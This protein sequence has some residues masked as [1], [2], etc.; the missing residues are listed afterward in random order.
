MTAVEV[1]EQVKVAGEIRHVSYISGS[2]TAAKGE[3]TEQVRGHYSK[4]VYLTRAAT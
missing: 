1:I 3:R 2:H 4:F